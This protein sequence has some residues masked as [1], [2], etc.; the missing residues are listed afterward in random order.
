MIIK[1]YRKN[2]FAKP[3]DEVSTV[4][5]SASSSE[6]EIVKKRN[7]DWWKQDCGYYNTKPDDENCLTK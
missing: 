4:S 2:L 3:N 1:I 6:N 5:T 7:G